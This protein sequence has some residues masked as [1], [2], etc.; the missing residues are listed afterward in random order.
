M[1]FVFLNK[2]NGLKPIVKCEKNRNCCAL[3][4]KIVPRIRLARRDFRLIDM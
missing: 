3:K 2:T 4:E 1:I